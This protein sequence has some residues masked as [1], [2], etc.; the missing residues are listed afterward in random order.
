MFS[1]IKLLLEIVC[2]SG[3]VISFFYRQ[4]IISI[5]YVS[6]IDISLLFWFSIEMSS[7]RKVYRKILNAVVLTYS[8]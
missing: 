3:I 8:K 4:S 7:Q 5:N 1:F 6:I 2:V